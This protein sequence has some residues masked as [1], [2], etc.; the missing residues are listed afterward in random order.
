MDFS[1]V[2]NHLTEILAILLAIFGPSG[3]AT[4]IVNLTDTPV[5]DG[6]VKVIY[7][8]LEILS[9]IWTSKAKQ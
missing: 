7:R 5:D 4:L 8:G 9:G 3:I 2:P 6:V 1:F